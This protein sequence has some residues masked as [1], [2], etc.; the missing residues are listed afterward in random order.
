MAHGLKLGVETIKNYLRGDREAVP[1][2]VLVSDGR[3]NVNL[4][5]GDP[6]EEAK[7]M[8]RQVACAGIQSIVLDTEQDFLSFGLV[9]QISDEMGGK[10][11]RLDEL[12][13]APIASA[14][15]SKLL[16]GTSNTFNN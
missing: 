2:I 12:S 15:R 9:K 5:G 4:H 16:T 3:A 13:A 1:L 10:Y 8:A 7:L 6:F 11:M 14:V